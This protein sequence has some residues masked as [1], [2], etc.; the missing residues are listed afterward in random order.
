L[1]RG[2]PVPR[3]WRDLVRARQAMILEVFHYVEIKHV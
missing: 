2:A 1:P 3:S